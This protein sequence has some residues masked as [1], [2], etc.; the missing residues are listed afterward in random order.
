MIGYN[1]KKNSLEA[2]EY[3][4]NHKTNL[5]YENGE[6]TPINQFHAQLRKKMGKIIN[7]KLNTKQKWRI[8]T[9]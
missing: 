5:T 6:Y 3:T 2:N 9:Q 1:H 7:Q 8:K 4:I